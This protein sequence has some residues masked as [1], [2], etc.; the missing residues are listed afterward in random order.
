[1]YPLVAGGDGIKIKPERMVPEKLYH[2]IYKEKIMLA[3]K[4]GQ[5]VLHCYE[6]EERALVDQVKGS[7]SDDEVE[8]IFEDYVAERNLNN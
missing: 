5:Q 7:K 3:Y 6:I 4:D 2:C 8:K 1:M